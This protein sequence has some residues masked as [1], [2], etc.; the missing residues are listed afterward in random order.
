MDS[1]ILGT[2]ASYSGAALRISFGDGVEKHYIL[3][4]TFKMEGRDIRH[5]RVDKLPVHLIAEKE[6]I[7]LLH[8]I[9]QTLHFLTGI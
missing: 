9:S 4:N 3:L 6:K 7:V 5:S 2:Q 1:L 8:D